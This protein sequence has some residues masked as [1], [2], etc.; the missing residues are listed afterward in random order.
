MCGYDSHACNFGLSSWICIICDQIWENPPYT[1]IHE[2][3]VSYMRPSMTKPTILRWQRI[4]ITK[5]NPWTIAPAYLKSL[6]HGDMSQN[7]P[8]LPVIKLQQ[9]VK[10]CYIYTARRSLYVCMSVYSPFMQNMWP[11]P[12]N[13]Q[14][15]KRL[16]ESSS[17]RFDGKNKVSVP[18]DR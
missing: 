8:R 9:A 15:P 10:H 3:L 4:T 11:R 13:Q 1:S 16:K 17:W 2:I 18:I 5:Y 12:L 7:V 14:L 6:A